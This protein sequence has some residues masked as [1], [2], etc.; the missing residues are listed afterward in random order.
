MERSAVETGKPEQININTINSPMYMSIVM[1]FFIK[2]NALC[3]A[4]KEN[5]KYNEN[6]TYTFT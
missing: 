5:N 3:L 2:I 6:C 4:Q 1:F